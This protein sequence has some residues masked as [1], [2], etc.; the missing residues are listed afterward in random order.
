MAGPEELLRAWVAVAPTEEEQWASLVPGPSVDEVA[1]RLSM[2]PSAFRDQL[3]DPAALAFD[4]LGIGTGAMG[5]AAAAFDDAAVRAGAGIALWLFAAEGPLGPLTP[6]L[7]RSRP[8]L[9][10]DALA[11]RL[12]A[13]TPPEGWGATAA[14]R[15]EAARTFLLWNGQLPA[16][17][18]V[19]GARAALAAVDSLQM[20]ALLAQSLEEHRHR[21]ALAQALADARAREAAARYMRE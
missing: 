13:A 4:V 18:D 6:P 14:R 8:G 12:V 1:T 10:V 7:L 16:G 2:T 15:E 11:L 20:D 5:L 17:E 19:A 21:S 9:A 3:L